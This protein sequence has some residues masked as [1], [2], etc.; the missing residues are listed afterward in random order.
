MLSSTPPSSACAT[1]AETFVSAEKKMKILIEMANIHSHSIGRLS[2]E[3]LC[4]QRD[5]APCNNL[6][7][8]NEA[9]IRFSVS[10][11]I[12]IF[13]RVCSKAVKRFFCA[14]TTNDQRIGKINRNEDSARCIRMPFAVSLKL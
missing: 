8:A 9:R 4:V 1:K 11:E 7:T 13:F 5:S 6:K 3:C 2:I 10:Y 12:S 14:P